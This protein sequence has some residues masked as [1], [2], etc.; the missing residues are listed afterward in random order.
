MPLVDL[1][2]LAV[3]TSLLIVTLLIHQLL[4]KNLVIVEFV[5]TMLAVC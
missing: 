2:I 4:F 3:S 5:A 1:Y